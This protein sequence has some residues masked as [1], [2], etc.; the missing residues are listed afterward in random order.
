MTPPQQPGREKHPIKY[1]QVPEDT[2]YLLIG[3]LKL[4]LQG[5]HNPR[6]NIETGINEL[7]SC[8][9]HSDMAHHDE[10]V[11]RELLDS[12][13][14]WLEPQSTMLLKQRMYRKLL[15]LKGGK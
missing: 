9:S 8:C 15:A 7:E 11:R 6:S 5:V 10:Q 3:I 14:A 4:D 1:F 2:V 12:L 13:I